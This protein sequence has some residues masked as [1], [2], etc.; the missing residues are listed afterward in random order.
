MPKSRREF[1]LLAGYGGAASAL[2]A[3]ASVA[4]ATS[5]GHDGIDKSMPS[6]L[7]AMP[8]PLNRDELPNPDMVRRIKAISNVFEVGRP[9][10]DYAYVENL[11][12]GRGF[13]VTQYGFCT[14]DSEVARVI[15]RY[16]AHVPDTPLKHFLSQLPPARWSEQNLDGFPHVWRKEIHA[17]ELLGR[18]CDEEADILYFAPAVESAAT[19]GITSPIGLSIFYDTLLQHG[20]GADPDSLPSILKRTLQENGDLDSSSETEFLRTFLAVRKSVLENAS[21]HATRNVWRASARRVDALSNLLEANPNLVPP[22]QVANA[23]I[24][25]TIL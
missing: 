10:P 18:A 17:S 19:I 7:D 5:R 25:A 23:D 4:H 15:N 11:G 20:A 14:Y 21:N 2:A 24:E 1:L 6:R 13:T 3:L 22:I 16:A 8:M 9:D 12:D